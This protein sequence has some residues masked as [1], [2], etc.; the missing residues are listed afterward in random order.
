M[1]SDTDT[2]EV[3]QE[4]DVKIE[5]GESGFHLYLDGEL[6][7]SK[8]NFTQGLNTNTEELAIGANIWARSDSNPL[9]AANE[10]EGVISDFTIRHHRPKLARAQSDGPLVRDLYFAND[11]DST[12]RKKSDPQVDRSFAKTRIQPTLS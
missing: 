2:I 8:T 5:F 11:D 9:Y 3:G 10:F 4:Y 1:Y 6:V 7:G 12:E